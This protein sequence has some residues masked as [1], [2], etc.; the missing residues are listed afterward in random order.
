MQDITSCPVHTRVCTQEDVGHEL[1]HM[2]VHLH[3]CAEGRAGR[4]LKIKRGREQKP[5]RIAGFLAINDRFPLGTVPRRAVLKIDA[6][7]GS[8]IDIDLPRPEH[9]ST[10]T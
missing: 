8:V 7:L 6:G 10:P 2:L 9:M 1:E 5:S 3:V 4:N